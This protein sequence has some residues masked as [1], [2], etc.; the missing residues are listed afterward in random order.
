MI[1]R[2]VVVGVDT[3]T[4]AAF[5]KLRYAESDARSVRAFLLSLPPPCAFERVDW[6]CDKNDLEI[7]AHVRTCVAGLGRGDL[8]LFYF[9]GH[10]VQ[11]LAGGQHLLLCRDA[12]PEVLETENS[13]GAIPLRTLDRICSGPFDRVLIFDACRK[14]SPAGAPGLRMRDTASSQSGGDAFREIARGSAALPM[15]G[16]TVAV[17]SCNDGERAA[18][19]DTL[20]AGL[21]THALL[22][23]LR[24][25]LSRQEPV[26]LD[27]EFV[28][29]VRAMMSSLSGVWL[30]QMPTICCSAE[31]IELVPAGSGTHPKVAMDE[32]E[33]H[34]Q[35][36][37]GQVVPRATYALAWGLFALGALFFLFAALEL[38]GV[39][40]L[41][42][43]LPDYGLSLP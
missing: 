20:R 15:R 17:W 33:L 28:A 32:V 10:G 34:P 37:D 19:S 36:R 22:A 2:A 5:E 42:L 27:Q 11:Q 4:H 25:A 35:P 21:F 41:R 26:V 43:F 18:E 12:M 9:A 40:I 23:Q 1:R 8:F 14:P 39:K 30:E 7:L 29:R 6:L 13:N 24:G 3:Y 31:A 16:R 38:A